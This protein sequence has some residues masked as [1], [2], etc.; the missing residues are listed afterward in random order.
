[1]DRAT[2]VVAEHEQRFHFEY[3]NTIFEAGDDLWR[4]DVAGYT[5]DKDV[6]DG[7]VENEFHRN[8]GIGTSEQGG[9]GLLRVD[10]VLFEDGQVIRN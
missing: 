2:T 5:R 8:T 9:E 10:G 6:A 4:H 1:L 7:L 3:G